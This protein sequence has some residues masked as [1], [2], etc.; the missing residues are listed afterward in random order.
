MFA[1]PLPPLSIL[2]RN[3]LTILILCI[4]FLGGGA[5]ST[6]PRRAPAK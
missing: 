4:L 1:P 2:D 3:A 6:L 5:D